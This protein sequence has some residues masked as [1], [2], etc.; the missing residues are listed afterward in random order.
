MNTQQV[1]ELYNLATECRDMS[2]QL[3][4][5][6]QHLAGQEAVDWLMAQASTQETVN[7]GELH[8]LLHSQGHLPPSLHPK[9]M[10]HSRSSVQMLTSHGMTSM[11]SFSSSQCRWHVT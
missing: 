1:A 4:W 8:M 2:T 7:A 5:E 10:Q 3:A 6:F 9:L 11:T